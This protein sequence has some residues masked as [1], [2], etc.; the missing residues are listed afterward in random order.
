MIWRCSRAGIHRWG[1][2]FESCIGR[3]C[4]PGSWAWVHCNWEVRCERLLPAVLCS[5]MS[6]SL[7]VCPGVEEDCGRK[8]LLTP[9]S[10]VSCQAMC[11]CQW[12]CNALG[13]CCVLTNI[14]A[15][16]AGFDWGGDWKEVP[17]EGLYKETT[18]KPFFLT[19]LC[20]FCKCGRHLV[21]HPIWFVYC[22]CVPHLW[23]LSKHSYFSHL[24]WLC[25]LH[26][27]SGI[28]GWSTRPGR[29]DGPWRGT[30]WTFG[31]TEAVLSG[32]P[33]FKCR[34]YGI[35]LGNVRQYRLSALTLVAR[36]SLFMWSAPGCGILQHCYKL[37]CL[38]ALE[39]MQYGSF[40]NITFVI[41]IS[42]SYS[43]PKLVR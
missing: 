18:H 32:C 37:F 8:H 24:A 14:A 19:Q 15:V 22:F 25:L 10:C 16:C 13:R 1:Q 12:L 21:W 23:R 28:G 40:S 9:S 31:I 20:Y 7:R 43:D 17:W 35:C 4:Q 38:C 26:R 39:S 36:S 29:L 6:V 11:S 2:R 33:W 27:N 30:W 5:G 3:S 41:K 34:N 42:G